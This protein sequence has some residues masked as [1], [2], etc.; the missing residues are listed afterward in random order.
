MHLP[1]R[2]QLLFIRLIL[3]TPMEIKTIGINL[4]SVISELILNSNLCLPHAFCRFCV[5]IYY[6]AKSL[7]A[8]IFFVCLRHTCNK[9]NSDCVSL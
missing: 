5:A 4:Y 2:R 1:A 6:H 8:I 7:F 3:I 9:Y